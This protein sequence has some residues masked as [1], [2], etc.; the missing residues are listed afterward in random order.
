MGAGS[1]ECHPW[2]YAAWTTCSPGPHPRFAI[3]S[4][5]SKDRG[6][7]SVI[8]CFCTSA[9]YGAEPERTK[10]FFLNSPCL[11]RRLIK[12]FLKKC[13]TPTEQRSMQLLCT[14]KP[15]MCFSE[16]YYSINQNSTN[17]FYMYIT[18]RIPL[19]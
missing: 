14:L 4:D 5:F 18:K 13:I 2:A 8:L 12:L 19:K 16:H 1:S 9:I 15:L 6:P 17:W 7:K 11:E 3:G 10:P